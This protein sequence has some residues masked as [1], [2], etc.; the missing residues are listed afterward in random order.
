MELP[1]ELPAEPSTTNSIQLPPQRGLCAVCA[2]YEWEYHFNRYDDDRVATDQEMWS[3]EVLANPSQAATL[4]AEGLSVQRSSYRGQFQVKQAQTKFT[5]QPYS[6]MFRNQESCSFCRLVV[7]AVESPQ[8]PKDPEWKKRD[9]TSTLPVTCEIQ[10]PKLELAGF[11]S[12]PTLSVSIHEPY[13]TSI[14]F[15][16]INKALSKTAASYPHPNQADENALKTWWTRCQKSH[17]KECR[18]S[19]LGSGIHELGVLR[20]IDVLEQCVITAPTDTPYAALSYKWGLDPIYTASKNEMMNGRLSLKD[21][22][23]PRTIRDAMTLVAIVGERY[24]WVD[25]LCIVQDDPSD[26]VHYIGHMDRIYKAAQF[27][28]INASGENANSGLEGLQPNSRKLRLARANIDGVELIEQP[29]LVRLNKSSWAQRAWTYQEYIFSPRKFI[30]ADG[31]VFYQCGHGISS[32]FFSQSLSRDSY[33]AAYLNPHLLNTN[34]LDVNT[35]GGELSDLSTGISMT[36]HSTPKDDAI[37]PLTYY[38]RNAVNYSERHA[39][40][41]SD[42][43]RAFQG[44]LSHMTSTHSLTF[45]WGMP[46]PW[47]HMVLGWKVWSDEYRGFVN[48]VDEATLARYRATR[49]RWDRRPQNQQARAWF[50]SWSWASCDYPLDYIGAEITNSKS[51]I[52]WPWDAGYSLQGS[53]DPFTSGVLRIEAECAILS[54]QSLTRQYLGVFMDSAIVLDDLTLPTQES[55]KFARIADLVV[56]DGELAVQ[57]IGLTESV[58]RPGTYRRF[59]AAQLPASTWDAAS[60]FREVIDLS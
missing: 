42:S 51:C 30:F 3:R 36:V 34:W 35:T 58:E 19:K 14:Q 55:M 28:I 39:T 23:I 27:T 46:I 1:A 21:K 7:S 33:Q 57:V 2:Q 38:V 16:N 5:L 32:E 59:C 29:K 12:T 44:I 11:L 50:P 24:L 53:P 47:F 52:I 43:L 20:L 8:W 60:S 18:S 4:V 40:S 6:T 17:G 45:C 9:T 25:A 15:Q 48:E 13:T 54:I 41:Q 49:Y 10:Q 31:C 22:P 56:K 26:V 37:P